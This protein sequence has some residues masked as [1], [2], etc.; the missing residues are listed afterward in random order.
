MEEMSPPDARAVLVGLQA[1]VKLDLPPAKVS[2]HSITE[3]G[4]KVDLTVVR[5]AGQRRRLAA[6]MFFHGGGWVLGDYPTHERL[7]RDLV[8]YSGATAVFVNYTPSPEAQYPRG[9]PAS[10]RRDEV[11][12]GERRRDQRRWSTAGRGWQQRRR[13]HGGRRL[14]D[15]QGPRWPGHPVPSL[16]WPVTDAYFDTESYH[17][18]AEGR[19]LT[20]NMMKWFWDNYTTERE[21]A[22]GDLRVALA[23]DDGRAAGLPR[24]WC[25][26]PATTCSATKAR[27]MRESWM[28]QAST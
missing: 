26:R 16:M 14:A 6:F 4:Q 7:V 10:V 1:S 11:G 5:P 12:R 9:D 28:S 27:S 15:G 18:Y 13:Q 17:E 22:D 19:F 2:S 21:R 24:P 3:D 8:A 20:R 25:R 23:S